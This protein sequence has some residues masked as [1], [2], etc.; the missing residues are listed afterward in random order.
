[1][2][3]VILAAGKGTRMGKY[4]EN[5]PKGMLCV[6]GKTLIERQLE[7]LRSAGISDIAIVTGYEHTKIDYNCVTYFHNAKFATTNMVESLMAAKDYIADS[8]VLVC[9]SDIL[10]TEALVK[11]C[12]ENPYHIGV[13][14][15]ADWRKLWQLRYGKVDFDL[16][17]LTVKNGL[18]TE[19]GR[20]VDS[21]D[22]LDYR[23]IGMIKFSKAGVDVLIN[24]YN[25]R[26]GKAWTQSGKNFEQGYMTDILSQIIN[27]G[28]SVEAIV[29]HGNWLE[30]D[31]E[32]DYEVL[33]E[34]FKKNLITKE[35]EIV[36]LL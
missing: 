15:D 2:K 11:Q 23:Y 10:Y 32:Q 13:A 26:I 7:T 28:N 21:S 6:E 12:V 30:F 36:E 14:V 22:G 27:D 20:E 19:L 35:L 33:S 4:T 29:S 8:D 3:A 34:A 31:T 1:M 5:L 24:T 9:Y 25:S 18:V 16:E 17:S